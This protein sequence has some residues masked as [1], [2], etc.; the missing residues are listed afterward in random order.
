MNLNFQ[1][2]KVKFVFV[3][4]QLERVSEIAIQRKSYHL[5]RY[6]ALI[7]FIVIKTALKIVRIYC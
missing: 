3:Y 5:F 1:Q 2:D 7:S 6:S 4:T